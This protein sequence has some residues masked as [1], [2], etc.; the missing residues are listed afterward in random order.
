MSELLLARELIM[1]RELALA[2]ELG[3]TAMLLQDT[4]GVVRTKE[5]E[6]SVYADE[7]K[8]K[9]VEIESLKAQLLL[10][11]MLV[12]GVIPKSEE[13]KDDGEYTV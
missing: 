7:L 9:N 2:R 3:C 6:L 1:A 10:M 13:P 12:H 5:E 11:Q 4:Y 8:A